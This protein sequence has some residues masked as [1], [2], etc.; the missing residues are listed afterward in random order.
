MVKKLS[1]HDFF[2]PERLKSVFGL[3]KVLPPSAFSESSQKQLVI[4]TSQKLT[5]SRLT[6]VSNAFWLTFVLDSFVGTN[7]RQLN[8]SNTML[9]CSES[10]AV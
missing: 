4:L 5:V 6:L 3:Q 8:Y 10:E 7:E 9:S 1:F 2:M